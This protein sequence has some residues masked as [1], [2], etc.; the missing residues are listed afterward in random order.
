MEKIIYLDNAATTKVDDLVVERVGEF[1][2]DSY[3]NPS[4]QYS[5]GQSVRIEIESAR[6]KI[7]K[8]IGAKSSEIIFTSG[9]TESNN[10]ALRGLAKAN[11][12]K[13]HIITS[14][15]EHPSILETCMDL[16][17]E[18]YN[19]DYVG[20]DS[21]GFVNVGE[22]E[23]KIREDT[24]VVSIM[25][26]N[27]EVGTIQ[28]IEE[29]GAICRSKKVPFHTD[30]VQSFTKLPIDVSRL[31]IDLLSVSGH[32]IHGPKGIGFLY[33]KEGVKISRV[34]TGGTQEK[35]LRGGTENTPG[36]IGIA[37]A[38]D[39]K[40]NSEEIKCIRDELMEG[41]MKIPNAKINGPLKKRIQNN[42][43]ISFE[44]IEGEALML[45]LSEDGICVSTG[46]ACM[47]TKV[48]ESYVLKAL[49]VP[50]SYINGSLRLSIKDLTKEDMNFVL[51]KISSG[52]S[53]LRELSPFKSSLVEL[54]L[55]AKK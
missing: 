30:A 1:L 46:S 53:K 44:G 20:V 22:I 15:I 42:I 51:E 6:K 26:V 36:I 50:N 8:F 39:L 34:I 55:G 43:N 25:H 49:G 12:N 16:E 19:V 9:A 4:S 10:L 47:S 35:N 24:L 29:V 7:A 40:Y 54:K 5:I 33:I 37:T 18:G 17:R 21:D 48:I 45:M 27:N 2:S 13:K 23:K 52:V 11:S 14:S 38:V 32:K 28:S 31:N 3:G 41:L